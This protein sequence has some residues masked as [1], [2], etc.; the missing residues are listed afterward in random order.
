MKQTDISIREKHGCYINENM[1]WNNCIKYLSS[2]LNTSSYMIN[3]LKNIMSPHVLRT[4]Y[5]T[6]F[7]VHLRYGL[8]LWSGD[9]ERIKIFWLQKKVIRIIGKV[10]RHVSC[11]NL[12]KHLNILPLPYLYIIEVVCS[13]NPLRTNQSVYAVSGTSRYLF[14]DKYKHINTARADHTIVEC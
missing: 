1:K 9:L 5:F 11:R 3:F 12:F 10:D 2:K 7:H 13:V 4:K 8:T 14:S 6:S